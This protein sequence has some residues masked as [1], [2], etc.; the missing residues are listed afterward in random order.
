M[1][2]D[3]AVSKAACF[4]S[5]QAKARHM[6]KVATTVVYVYIDVEQQSDGI[7]HTVYT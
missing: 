6:K 4:S 3:T 5:V 1:A 7:M 2:H